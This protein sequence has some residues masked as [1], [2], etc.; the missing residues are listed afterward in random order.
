MI[1]KMN[2]EIGKLAR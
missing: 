2:A 1:G